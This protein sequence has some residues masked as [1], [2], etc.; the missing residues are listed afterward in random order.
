MRTDPTIRLWRETVSGRSGTLVGQGSVTIVSADVDYL[1]HFRIHLSQL[2]VFGAANVS[3]FEILCRVYGFHPSVNC[4]RMFY[5]S[6]YNKGWMSFI[7]C[8]DAA[9]ICYSKQLDF[10]KNWN[11][12]F[13]WVDSTVFPLFVSLKKLDLFAFVRYSDP[14]KVVVGERN[15][16]NGE[17]KLLVSTKGRTVPLVP[18]A[19][20]ASKNSGDSIDKLFDEGNDAEQGRSTEKGDDVLEETISKDVLEI[21]VEKTKK[22]RKSKAVGDASGSTH[23]PKRLREDFYAATSDIGGKSLADIRGLI[24]EDSSMYELNLRTRPL[25]AWSFVTDVPVVTVVA[26]TTIVADVSSILPPRL[27]LYLEVLHLLCFVIIL[28]DHLTDHLA[29]PSFFSQLHAMEYDQ[30]YADFNVGAARQM[31]LWAEVRMR[32]EHTLEQKNRL[33]DKCSEQ[34]ARLLE[35]DAEIA[36]LRS[37][38]SLKEFEAAEAIRLCEQVSVVEA[39]DVVKGDE[40]R[41]FVG[42]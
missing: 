12:H 11:D 26:T 34:S 41:D 3:H 22:K 31:C 24:P 10:V 15:V 19:P 9:P 14:T 4:F 2:S 18:P 38:L 20:A 32:A 36:H 21:A 35:K 28:T 27:G 1:P 13:F 16:T 5:T 17:A 29:P 33:E 30:L 37:L 40:Q 6:S 39:A 23:P 25:V 7:K 8:S 42:S